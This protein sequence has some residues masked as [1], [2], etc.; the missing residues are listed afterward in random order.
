MGN[1]MFFITIST[2]VYK[3][4]LGANSGAVEK[5]APTLQLLSSVSSSSRLEIT[6]SSSFVSGGEL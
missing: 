5:V 6:L 3:G 2:A 4:G 1:I